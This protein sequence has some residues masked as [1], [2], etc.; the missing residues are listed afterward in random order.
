ML[1]HSP[2]RRICHSR[3][4]LVQVYEVQTPEEAAALARL[5]V[6]HVAVLVGSGAFPR[7]LTSARAAAIF[8]AVPAGT[9]RVALSLS[10]EPDEIAAVIENTRPDII[11]IGAAAELFSVAETQALKTEFPDVLFMRAIPILDHGSIELA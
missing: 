1:V 2:T 11:H 3:C 9:R 4:V 7:E 8:A 10:A 5:G 6:D